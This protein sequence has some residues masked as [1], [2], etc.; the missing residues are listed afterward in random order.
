MAAFAGLDVGT[1]SSK[2]VSGVHHCGRGADTIDSVTQSRAGVNTQ[3][4][5]VEA[6]AAEIGHG[7]GD[8]G[9]GGGTDADDGGDAGGP[10]RCDSG[11]RI[12][13]YGATLRG[14]LQA[15]CGK[16]VRI[17]ERFAVFDVFTGD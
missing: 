15:P 13:E 16:Q 8:T 4:L 9:S 17:G 1:T 10:R 7:H 6:D 14:N 12:L 5:P 11:G 3:L 2:A